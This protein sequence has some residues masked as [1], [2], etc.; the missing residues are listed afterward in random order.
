MTRLISE[1]SN[2]LGIV[3]QNVDVQLNLEPLKFDPDTA[4]PISLWW[5]SRGCHR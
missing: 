5:R 2:G 4:I 1:L 3:D